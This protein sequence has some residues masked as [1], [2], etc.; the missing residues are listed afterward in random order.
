MQAKWT[1]SVHACTVREYCQEY[2][3]DSS[4]KMVKNKY[5]GN[6][7][8]II[9]LTKVR[10]E[11]KVKKSKTFTESIPII[12]QLLHFLCLCSKA[13]SSKRAGRNLF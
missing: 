12:F 10:A 8:F 9:C 6:F 11:E 1:V 7:G 3:C 2:E 5:I 13:V 4:L